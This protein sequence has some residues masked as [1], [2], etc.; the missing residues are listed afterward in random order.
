MTCAAYGLWENHPLTY[1]AGIYQIGS[2]R[3]TILLMM[4]YNMLIMI[5][6]AS[7]HLI[8]KYV[9]LLNGVIYM[10]WNAKRNVL[11]L[12]CDF[13]QSNLNRSLVTFKQNKVKNVVSLTELIISI[14]I[15]LNFCLLFDQFL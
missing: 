5:V 1:L 12:K 4:F 10:L 14:I 9:I 7:R 2:H 6:V 3:D 15:G 8:R 11:L 13:V